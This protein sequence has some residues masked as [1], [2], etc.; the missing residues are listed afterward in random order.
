VEYCGLVLAG[1]VAGGNS[2]VMEA[3]G[4][5]HKE[6]ISVV[7]DVSTGIGNTV[8]AFNSRQ[9]MFHPDSNP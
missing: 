7:F 9:G 4:N 2:Q 8:I 6:I 3:T 5:T 1:T